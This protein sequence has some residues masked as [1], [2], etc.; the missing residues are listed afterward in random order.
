[1]GTTQQHLHQRSTSRH[2]S[3]VL[4]A[5]ALVLA[6]LGAFGGCDGKS[7]QENH[8]D[9]ARQ[10]NI[11]QIE[12]NSRKYEHYQRQH[13]ETI[14]R[15]QQWFDDLLALDYA[16][17]NLPKPEKQL[18]GSLGPATPDPDFCKRV[19]ALPSQQPEMNS[20]DWQTQYRQ[21]AAQWRSVLFP[22]SY[23]QFE[24][25][26]L[27]ESQLARLACLAQ[28]GNPALREALLELLIA[29]V[30][31]SSPID[32]RAN[33]ELDL[34]PG[35]EEQ[36]VAVH[37]VDETVQY[38]IAVYAIKH[39]IS[40]EKGWYKLRE[41]I[42]NGRFFDF[43]AKEKIGMDPEHFGLGYDPNVRYRLAKESLQRH[44]SRRNRPRTG[45]MHGV[46]RR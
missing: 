29:P 5:A 16:T 33:T 44:Q 46:P 17:L 34:E 42:D 21:Y 41:I 9:N 7:S 8:R 10:E 6:M 40:P 27:A 13:L 25:H 14:E 30:R 26:Y 19:A 12:Q 35:F 15:Y 24:E 45:T 22:Q 39:D 36:L 2:C 32:G 31:F 28:N 3:E 4:V 20:Q 18:D 11:A 23:Q 43:S 1:M 38:T 37:E